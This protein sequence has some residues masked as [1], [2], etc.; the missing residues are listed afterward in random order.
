[1]TNARLQ[2]G[3]FPESLSQKVLLGPTQINKMVKLAVPREQK[4]DLLRECIKGL[5]D[6]DAKG[7]VVFCAKF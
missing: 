1:L 6:E 3:H 2:H 5:W 4:D 7:M